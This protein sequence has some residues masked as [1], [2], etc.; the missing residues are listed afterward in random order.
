M[1]GRTMWRALPGAQP[2][3]LLGLPEKEEER[4]ETARHGKRNKEPPPPS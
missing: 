2:E 3:I 1:M 4:N